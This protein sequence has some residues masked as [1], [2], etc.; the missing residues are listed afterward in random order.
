MISDRRLCALC[1]DV[2]E[3]HTFESP[4]KCSALL[5]LEE[6]GFVILAFRGSN[7]RLDW[8]RNFFAL[9][10]HKLHA[11]F[12][13]SAQ[14][15]WGAVPSPDNL[16]LTGH[17]AGGAIAQILAL[18]LVAAKRPIGKLTTFGAPPIGEGTLADIPGS[19]YRH[20]DDPVPMMGI[21]RPRSLTQLGTT[22]G[23]QVTWADH[24]IERYLAA[25]EALEG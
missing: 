9:P 4:L 12:L 1:H 5:R 7:S 15:A 20:G 23:R 22:E 24:A 3:R 6:D 14:A 11:G 10:F 19:D 2:Y 25:L 8:E 21:G 17:S 13:A 16:V 18:W